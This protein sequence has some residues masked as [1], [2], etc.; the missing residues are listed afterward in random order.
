MRLTDV[1][2]GRSGTVHINFIHTIWAPYSFGRILI[3]NIQVI[4]KGR[5]S[6][7]AEIS[8]QADKLPDEYVFTIKDILK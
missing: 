3:K 5:D 7:R 2:T 8:R 1:K 4:I 6:F